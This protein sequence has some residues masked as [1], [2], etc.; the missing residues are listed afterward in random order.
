MARGNNRQFLLTEAAACQYLLA[1]L[2]RAKATYPAKLYHYC[3]M[4]N[5]IH[6]LLEI[7]RAEHLP[8]FMPLVLQGYAR[9][10]G[11]R[12]RYSGHVWQGCYKSP[13]VEKDSYYLEAGRYIERNPLRANVVQDLK[14][15]PWSSYPVYAYGQSTPL[16]DEDPYYAPLGQSPIDRQT[17]YRQ[18]LLTGEAACRYFL[19]LLARAKATYPA[20]LYHDCLMSNHVYV[21]LEIATAEHLPK[22]M[23]LVLQGYARWYGK[24]HSYS[25]HVWQGRDKSPLVEKESYYLEAGRYIERNP[26]RAKLVQDLKDY[27]WSSYLAYA[28]GQSNALVDEDPY[29]AQLGK[30]PVDRQTVY[31]KF[32]RLESPYAPMLDRELVETPF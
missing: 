17:A 16:V 2:A 20:K 24:R 25:G 21:L 31:R 30:S 7:A 28:D 12:H 27:P 26:L 18:F 11:K 3:L 4:S 29:Y 14:D 8:K 22:F 1:L 9:W 10:Y 13:L 5:H 15:Y 32:V 6:W 19:D 23:Q